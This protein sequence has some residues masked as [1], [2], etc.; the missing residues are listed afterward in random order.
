MYV[1]GERKG[2]MVEPGMT[3][4]NGRPMRRLEGPLR[5]TADM[6]SDGPGDVSVAID[7]QQWVI[8][9]AWTPG[10]E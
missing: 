7:R 6:Q 5:W 3:D 4:Q 8:D 10:A 2:V 9:A 1:N